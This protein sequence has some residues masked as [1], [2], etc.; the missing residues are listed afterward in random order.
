LALAGLPA[1]AVSWV[2]A[3][4]VVCSALVGPVIKPTREV[5]VSNQRWLIIC[6]VLLWV[7]MLAYGAWAYPRLPE[8]YPTRFDARG[9]PVAWSNRSVWHVLTMPLVFL[10]IIAIA[11]LTLRYPHLANYPGKHRVA[12]LPPER[13]APVY[14]YLRLGVLRLM[15]CVGVVMAAV[16]TMIIHSAMTGRLEHFAITVSLLI[17]G[18]IVPA[19][20]LVIGLHRVTRQALETPP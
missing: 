2:V 10:L 3:L 8:H 16:Q 18:C 14:D 15:L 17:A 20:W 12:A 6:M 7:G 19:V 4:A 5:P 1:A 9:K 13:R 11:L